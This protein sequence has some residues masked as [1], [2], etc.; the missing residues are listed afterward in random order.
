MTDAYDAPYDHDDTVRARVTWAAVRRWL[1]LIVVIT[2]AAGAAGWFWAGSKTPTYTAEGLLELTDDASGNT[3]SFVDVQ[4]MEAQRRSLLSNDMRHVLD[5][6]LGESAGSLTGVSAS[7]QDDT[8]LITVS[9]TA[10]EP[11]IAIT[12]V[13][14]LFTIY[15]A[16]RLD[17]QVAGFQVLLDEQ[18]RRVAE[19]QANV[20]QITANLSAATDGSQRRALEISQQ[21]AV[22]RLQNLDAEAQ[23]LSSE[24]VLADG[25]VRVAN[26]PE[27]ASANETNQPFTAAQFA[28]LGLLLS[29]GAVVAFGSRNTKLRLVDEIEELLPASIPVLATVPQF[30]K[31]FR[32]RQNAIVIGRPDAMREAEAFRFVRTSIELATSDHATHTVAITSATPGEGKTVTAANLALSLAASG[33]RTLLIDGDLISP[34]LPQLSGRP[35][36][37]NTLPHLLSGQYA[38]EELITNLGSGER[39]L[40]LLISNDV[41]R[42]DGARIELVPDT[43]RQTFKELNSQYQALVVDCPP[44]LVVS[45]ALATAA[46]A[47]FTIVVVRLGQARRREVSRTIDSLR[48]NGANVLGVIAT[49]V[50]SKGGY[51]YGSYGYGSYEGRNN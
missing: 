50:D 43:M 39:T 29:G 5:A 15:T 45:D 8:T 47:D 6:A 16:L 35:D 46:A 40:D 23:E 1:P 9:V 48:Q 24:I 20:D 14:E 25:R 38:P 51:G 26:R 22:N 49:F 32:D 4:E 3:R 28:V 12:A 30:R 21:S 10:T 34:S 37:V 31:Q 17:E 18:L 7:T 41:I 33:S 11:S 27:T 36:A 13:E 44:A 19:Q 42:T 2:A